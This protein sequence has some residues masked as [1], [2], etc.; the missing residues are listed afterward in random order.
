M[1][2]ELLQHHETIVD[3]TNKGAV[4][5]GAMTGTGGFMGLLTSN[6]QAISVL[7]MIGGF[8]VAVISAVANHRHRK[9]MLELRGKELEI[10]EKQGSESTQP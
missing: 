6:A 1:S 2:N 4:I 5:I 8:A 3:A 9:K 10:L 7:V